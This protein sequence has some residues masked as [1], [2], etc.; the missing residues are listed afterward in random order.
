MLN[1]QESS[2]KYLAPAKKGYKVIN[3]NHVN[4]FEYL[5]GAEDKPEGYPGP[6]NL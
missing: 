2:E 4:F 6:I 3:D 1:S 5:N